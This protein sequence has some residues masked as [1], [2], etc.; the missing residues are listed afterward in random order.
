MGFVPEFV[1]FGNFIIWALLT[2]AWGGSLLYLVENSHAGWASFTV[3]VTLVFLQVCTNF[4]PLTLAYQHPTSALGYTFLYLVAGILVG[5]YKWWRFTVN[6]NTAYQEKIDTMLLSNNKKFA[7]LDRSEQN[8]YLDAAVRQVTQRQFDYP[9]HLYQHKARITTW[10]TYWPVTGLWTL[11][12]DPVHS[13]YLYS[14][15]QITGTL[16][17]IADRAQARVKPEYIR[18]P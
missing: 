15:E 2:V 1:F 10:M 12:K 8:N 13:F 6:V 4:Q 17:A 5:L 9:L 16:Q 3:A 18:T 7:E 14:Y 11:L